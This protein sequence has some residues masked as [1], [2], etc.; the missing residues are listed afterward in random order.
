[1]FWTEEIAAKCNGAQIINDSKTPSGRVHVGALRGV[2]IHDAIFRT[3]KEKG[4]EARYLFGV[5]DYDPV[6]EIPKGED[7]HFGRYIGWPLCNTPA[8]RGSSAPD[9]AEHFMSEFREIFVDLGVKA[10]G[11]RMRDLY[12]SGEFNEPIDM[13]LRNAEKVRRVYK[14]VSGAER[15]A[16]WLPFQVICE[17]CGCIGTTE[18]SDYDG[19]DV[20]YMCRMDKVVNTKLNLGRGCGYEGKVSP[21][22][23]RGKLPWKL[24]WVAKWVKFPV[25]I[26]GAGKDHSTKGGSRDVS[27]ACLRA[28]YGIEPPLRVPYEFFLVGGAK[29]S[30][31]KGVGASARDM[32][33]LLPP[34]VLRFLMIRTKPNSPVNF[35]VRE[36]GI[37]KLFNEFDRFHSRAE[38][39]KNATPDEACV[40]RLSELTPEGGYVN[41]NF[42]LVSALVQMPHLDPVKEIEKRK[43]AP[44]TAIERR[45][46][47]AR[48]ASAKIWVENYASEEEKTRLQETLPA[49]A[50]ELTQTQR[51]FLQNLAAALPETAWEDN[52]LQ[53]K[54]FEVARMTPIEQPVA[55]KA[56]YRVLLDR[57]A[58]PKAGNLLAFL[59]RDFVIARF[60][61]LECDRLAFWRESAVTMDALENWITKEAEKIASRDSQFMIEGGVSANEFIFTLKDGKRLLKRVIAES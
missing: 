19:R 23:G 13:I 44:L 8:P 59:D 35:D 29:M 34:E 18:V 10:E 42:Q 51:A 57:E 30:S 31:S 15:P 2:L 38:I 28:I 54:V 4:I 33:N 12:R 20:S 39:E 26:E 36:E 11:Y 46:L 55:F 25:T 16:H 43:G 49:R 60:R 52:A 27:E 50:Q 5:D 24:E 1:M 7:E 53:A 47:D 45:H 37:V 14:E 56:I 41:A 40:H 3:L 32:A 22:D 48:I 17:K 6:D 58:G 9:M 21:F 61:E